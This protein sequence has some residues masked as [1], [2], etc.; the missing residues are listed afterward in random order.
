MFP[1]LRKDCCF[2]PDFQTLPTPISD[3]ISINTKM[4]VWYWLSDTKRGKSKYS[5]MNLSKFRFVDRID[6]RLLG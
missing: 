4:R 1:E 3:N 2:F 5:E 6:P